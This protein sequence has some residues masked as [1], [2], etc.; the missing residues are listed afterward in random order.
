MAECVGTLITSVHA[1]SAQ[2][3]LSSH[4][5][6]EAGGPV[7]GGHAWEERWAHHGNSQARIKGLCQHPRIP[8]ATSICLSFLKNY[9]HSILFGSV[10]VSI[11]KDSRLCWDLTDPKAVGLCYCL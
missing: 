11:V 9:I 6:D 5:S 4:K 7:S 1:A 3:Q 2:P 10:M 8:R